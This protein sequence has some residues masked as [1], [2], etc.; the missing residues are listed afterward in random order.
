MIEMF[1]AEVRARIKVEWR[2]VKIRE[3][4]K[5]IDHFDKE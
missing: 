5:R 2:I 1:M 4:R 3:N